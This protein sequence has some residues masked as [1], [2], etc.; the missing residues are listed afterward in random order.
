[1]IKKYLIVP[2]GKINHGQLKDDMDNHPSKKLKY[3]VI[4]IIN[5]ATGKAEIGALINMKPTKKFLF[6]LNLHSEKSIYKEKKRI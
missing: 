2:D 1:M 4:Y 3:T 5:N 6:L